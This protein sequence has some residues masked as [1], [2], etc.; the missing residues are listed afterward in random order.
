M[1]AQLKLYISI[2]CLLLIGVL[3]FFIQHLRQDNYKLK[4]DIS[5]KDVLLMQWQQKDILQKKQMA[6]IESSINVYIATTAILE[7]QHLEDQ[8]RILS[9]KKKLNDF[10]RINGMFLRSIQPTQSMRTVSTSTREINAE[11]ED[12]KHY[13]A[14]RVA[15]GINDGLHQCQA[16]IIQLNTLIDLLNKLYDEQDE[17]YNK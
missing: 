9:D 11:S 3:V 12:A 1:I 14:H 5:K 10:N 8:K 16:Y 17:F 4:Q 13:A 6:T 7:G 15:A 2:G